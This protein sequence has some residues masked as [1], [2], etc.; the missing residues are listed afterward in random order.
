[1]IESCPPPKLPDKSHAPLNTE[2]PNS[3]CEA[4]DAVS[5]T[6][7]RVRLRSL[8]KWLGSAVRHRVP[9]STKSVRFILTHVILIVKVFQVINTLLDRMP[10]LRHRLP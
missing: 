4:S 8:Q 1:V 2:P 5:R 7:L 9:V 10:Q 6:E 3:P